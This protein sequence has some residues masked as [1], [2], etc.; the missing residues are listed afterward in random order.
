MNKIEFRDVF[1]SFGSVDA[2]NG[3]ELQIGEGCVHALL[4]HNGAGKTTSLRLMLGLLEADRGDVSV[5]G[6]QPVKDGAKVRSMCGVLSENNGLYEPLTLYDNLIYYADIYGMDRS[7][8]N[9]RIDELLERLGLADKKFVAVKGFSTGMKKKAALAR[10]MLHSPKILLLDEPTNG[11]DP[12]STADLRELLS[13]L[14]RKKNTTIIMTTHNLEEVQKVCDT[15]SIMRRGQNIFSD[16]ISK[17]TESRHY[18]E[19]GTFS[20]EKLYMDLESRF[21]DSSGK[22]TEVGQ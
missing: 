17:L 1:K 11:L 7:D 20:L 12:V 8:S 2:I 19:H 22:Q 10:A 3:L 4:G 14:S 18:M 21:S 9:R 5:F 16:S 13:E 15:I 6:L